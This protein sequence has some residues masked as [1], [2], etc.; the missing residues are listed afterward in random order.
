MKKY[1]WEHLDWL[2]EQDRNADTGDSEINEEPNIE[3]GKYKV[4]GNF[5]IEAYNGEFNPLELFASPDLPS[6]KVWYSFCKRA[7]K[8]NL[9]PLL[10]YPSKSS[11][12]H[13]FLITA[14]WE[15]EINDKLKV[16][17][18]ATKL[19]E[20]RTPYLS[21]VL[22]RMGESFLKIK[23]SDEAMNLVIIDGLS[24]EDEHLNIKMISDGLE[25]N[26][27]ESYLVGLRM[28][29]PDMDD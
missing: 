18:P 26:V 22:Y 27:D 8:K 5:Y 28:Q 13:F 10:Y 25:G 4:L 3:M 20:E 12:N 17:R 24:F 16:D 9:L 21:E 6:A 11:C 2:W 23:F 14:D 29:K 15:M 7:A 1:D 19:I